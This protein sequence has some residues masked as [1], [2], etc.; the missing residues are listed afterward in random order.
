MNAADVGDERL[1]VGYVMSRF[2]KLS[3]TFVL[4]EV[5]ALEEL[6]VEVELF[7]LIR[8]TEPVNHRE[9]ERLAARA[10]YA[11][12]VSL[13]VLAAQLHWL[14]R[15]PLKYLAVWARAIFGNVRSPRFLL[16]ALAV[17]PLAAL[18]ARR[19]EL[20]GVRHIHAHWATHPALAAYVASMLTGL[21]YSFTAHAHDIFVDR[22]MLQEKVRRATFIVTISEYNRRFLVDLYG[23]RAGRK[24]SVIHCGTDPA[25][26]APPERP[27]GRSPWT[28]LCI[29]SLQPQKGQTYL[30]EA[31]R[32]LA[33]SGDID[34]RC[35]LV[36]EGASRGALEQQIA[37]AGLDAH[38]KL[39]GNQ[40]RHRVVELLADADVV[41][42]PSI[43]LPSGKKEGIP[44]ALMEALS[45][46]RPAVATGLSGV[47]ELISDGITGL[48]VP[49]GDAEALARALRNLYGDREFASALG[50]AGRERV[51]RDFNLHEGARQLAHLF[52]TAI[53]VGRGDWPT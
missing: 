8:E 29:A 9:A 32:L 50:R 28:I 35:L 33:A 51:V 23:E 1:R 10:H 36:G 12:L 22:P 19:M 3:E 49:E 38:V 2:P 6:G 5:L 39:L 46:E 7:P 20:L 44:V 47:P 52:G 4:Y 40:P 48:L 41:V 24:L 34:F 16:R 21:T 18:M 45:M 27:A 15:H 30:L 11:S 17:V 53:S 31:C 26:F 13:T 42:Q 37:E 25:V 43:T 14:R